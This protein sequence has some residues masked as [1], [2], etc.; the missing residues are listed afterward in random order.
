[1]TEDDSLHG[2]QPRQDM[3]ARLD[4]FEIVPGREVLISHWIFTGLLVDTVCTIISVNVQ[5]FNVRTAEADGDIN[6][7]D[8][9]GVWGY[10][11]GYEE[12]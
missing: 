4:F 2:D 3:R 8:I 12:R 6:F 1:M 9:A 7:E 5:G 11:D 10:L